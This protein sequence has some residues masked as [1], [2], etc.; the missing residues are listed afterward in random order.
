MAKKGQGRVAVEVGL[1]ERESKDN[2]E[3]F[4]RLLPSIPIS[5]HLY[6]C[7]NQAFVEGYQ[8]YHDDKDKNC[9]QVVFRSIYSF[10]CQNFTQS[11]KHP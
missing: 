1:F 3:T 8:T 7:Y 5:Q 10:F 11:L 9:A 6:F 2:Q 4:A